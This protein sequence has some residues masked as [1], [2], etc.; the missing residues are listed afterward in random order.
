MARDVELARIA[1][2]ATG[3]VL[4]GEP[5]IGKSRLLIEA[6]ERL[7]PS[8]RRVVQ[9]AGT[10]S[11]S[12]VP[13]GAFAGA[14]AHDLGLGASF[15]A[16]ARAVA[17]LGDDGPLDGVI[18]AVDD[19]HLLDDASAGLVHVAAKAGARV[20]ATV[21]AREQCPDAV[22]RL[23][24]DDIAARI[25]VRPLDERG[26]GNVLTAALGSPLDERSRRRLFEVT[27]GN[28][29][30]LREIVRHALESGAMVE[31]R[32]SWTWIEPDTVAP[33]V[34]D[35]VQERLARIE[36]RVREVV[37]VL[38]VGEP[39]GR[40]IVEGT[41]SA[42]AIRD[43]L[44]DGVVS[45]VRTG[46]RDELRL[47]HPMYAQVVRAA[48]ERRQRA[49]I[50][51]RIADAL[52]AAGA[53]RRDDRLRIAIMRLDAGAPSDARELDA[54][55]REAGSRGDLVLAERF[56]RAALFA[57]GGATSMV[58]LGQVLSIA[59][60]RHDEVIAL[61]G[62]EPRAESEAVIART[63]ILTA[64]SLFF[65]LGRVDEALAA[66]ERAVEQVDGD[67]RMLLVAFHSE[68]LMYAGRAR[69]SIDVGA[70]VLA[71]DD[72]PLEARLRAYTGVLCSQANC[73]RFADV[74]AQLARAMT[75]VRATAPDLTVYSSAGA[76]VATFCVHLFTGRLAETDALLGALHADA[77][78]RPADPYLGAW[79]FLLGR[80]A[81]AQ[82]H[83]AQAIVRL[84]DATSLLRA[85]DPGETLP[86][87]LGALAQALG[88][89]DDAVGAKT[90]V[91]EMESVRT[92]SLHHVDF[93]LDL[94]RA[95]AAAAQGE[96]SRACDIALELGRSL[97]DDGRIALGALALHDALRL[98]V[99]PSGVVESLE[100]VAA[101]SDGV[102][103]HA[104]ARHARAST[105][106]DI[107]DLLAAADEL[108]R[109]GWVLHAAEA[110][111]EASRVAA[112]ARL[113]VRQR[114][115]SI[116]SAALASVCG[117]ALTPLL[118]T[119]G[120]KESLR[121][122]T[123]REQEVALLAARGRSKREIAEALFLSE[124]TVGN[125]I[126]HVY[127]KLGIS[128]RAEL[129]IALDIARN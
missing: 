5:G 36:P 30:F 72:A 61:L 29:L 116:R 107:D 90:I 74:E 56:A 89:A 65:G 58:L 91:D 62:L 54:M 69:E 24:K 87:A 51:G 8:A 120:G 77:L 100:A 96:R 55:A 67:D 9:V 6:V 28:L 101:S 2:T 15:D 13:F 33:G 3:A 39:L 47:V 23:W 110:A 121:L 57:G 66:V 111:A 117:P 75:E 63:T 119:V 68:L 106:R 94:G 78:R 35:L 31:R 129:G 48:F 80:S 123:R 102:V 64:A 114:E 18:L 11:L 19:A 37:D 12:A 109:V 81:L 97:V 128:S 21:R 115:A 10:Q 41:C 98:G 122:L 86:W 103:L 113:R 46:M 83:L 88:A 49:A 99:D 1:E 26:V 4:I 127:G 104:F 126:N 40:S 84:R 34:L 79:S 125:H 85:H 50:A 105:T 108:E 92:L 71:N 70:D 118:E 93:D 38:A 20:L 16:L 7:G 32:G 112:D 14:L 43:A 60:R 22:V 27:E 76:L 59:G 25:D 73:G 17:A 95:W 82:G 53:L 42:D 44:A 124:R 45:S 52:S